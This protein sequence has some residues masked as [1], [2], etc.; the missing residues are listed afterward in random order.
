LS[1]LGTLEVPLPRIFRLNSNIV[2]IEGVVI[3]FGKPEDNFITSGEPTRGMETMLKTPN[4]SITQFEAPV[5]EHRIVVDIQRDHFTIIH[6]VPD[7]P[8]YTTIRVKL[9]YD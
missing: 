1:L 7:L 6:I 5:L 8:A 2:K 3:R 9:V 4:D